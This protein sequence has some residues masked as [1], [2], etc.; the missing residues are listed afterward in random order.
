MAPPAIEP[1]EP[2]E[3]PRHVAS[4]P[5]HRPAA[6]PSTKTAKPTS[7]SAPAHVA[8]PASPVRVNGT[9]LADELRAEATRAASTGAS[10]AEESAVDYMRRLEARLAVELERI[11]GF[12]DQLRVETEYHIRADGRIERPRVI[13]AS[14][15]PNFDRAVL[16]VL[17]GFEAGPRPAGVDELQHTPFVTRAR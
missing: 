11:P 14:R 13:R 17:D 2:A 5:V 1:D 8:S 10:A 12:D 9:A 4:T 3:A 16:Q 7:T 6:K 15:D